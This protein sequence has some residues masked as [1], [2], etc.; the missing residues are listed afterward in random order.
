MFDAQPDKSNIKY[1]HIS[2][3]TVFILPHTLHTGLP[4]VSPFMYN[5]KILHTFLMF[6]FVLYIPSNAVKSGVVL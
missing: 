4:D 3:T 2:L 6:P 1:Y 5:T